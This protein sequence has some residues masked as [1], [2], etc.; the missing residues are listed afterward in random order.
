MENTITAVNN[1]TEEVKTQT[2]LN[3]LFLLFAEFFGYVSPLIDLAENL[4]EGKEISPHMV[5][6]INVEAK[7]LFYE[8]QKEYTI[9]EIATYYKSFYPIVLQD[10]DKK[11]KEDLPF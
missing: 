5:K 9:E 4:C 6:L 2:I 8:M 7:V 1:T 11:L 10:Y 3:P